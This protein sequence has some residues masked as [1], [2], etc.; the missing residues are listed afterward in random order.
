MHE[1]LEYVYSPENIPD[2]NFMV[3]LEITQF[4]LIL[5]NPTFGLSTC[6]K[7][8]DGNSRTCYKLFQQD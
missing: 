7:V 5:N 2:K 3:N 6:Y 1:L 8:D 4:E